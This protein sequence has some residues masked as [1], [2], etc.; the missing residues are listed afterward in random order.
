MLDQVVDWLGQYWWLLWMLV[1][2]TALVR[3]QWR[4][5]RNGHQRQKRP[6]WRSD[7]AV[8]RQIKLVGVGLA[9]IGIFLLM[10]NLLS[11]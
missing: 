11:P 5:T 8:V 2:V 4:R 1:V 6:E 10:V 7:A 3:L 9:V